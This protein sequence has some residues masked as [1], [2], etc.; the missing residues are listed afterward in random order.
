MDAPFQI[1]LGYP[2]NVL[3]DICFRLDVVLDRD[4]GSKLEELSIY[5]CS[6]VSII[7]N[8]FLFFFF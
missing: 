4:R 7:F 1:N 6:N 8:M 3:G 5:R 2:I